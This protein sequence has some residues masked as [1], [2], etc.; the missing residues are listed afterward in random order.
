MH[1]NLSI[2]E[3][4]STYILLV[5]TVFRDEGYEFQVGY[6]INSRDL[7]QRTPLHVAIMTNN[8]T[9]ALFLVENGADINAC[10]NRGNTSLHM[11]LSVQERVSLREHPWYAF[12]IKRFIGKKDQQRT[13]NKETIKKVRK[14]SH[15]GR[16]IPCFRIQLI[17]SF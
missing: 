4:R 16:S 3:S 9:A 12:P 17:V 2:P 13:V 1:R 11:T 10:D 8:L 5:M 14:E 15:C 7:D 6:D